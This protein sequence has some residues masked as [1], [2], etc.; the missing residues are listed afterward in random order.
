MSVAVTVYN[1]GRGLV[2]EERNIDLAAGAN[3]VRFMDVAE[4]IQAPT[5]RVAPIEGAPF[6]VLEQNYEYDLLSPA[7]LLD[8]FVGQT[9][10]LVQQKM[11]NNSTVE[12]SVEAKLLSN[13]SGTV[14][15]IGGKIVVNPPY[16][17]MVFPNVPE[18]LIAKPTLVWQ[19]GAPTAGKRR[20]EASYI[21]AGMQWNATDLNADG[22]KDP[23]VVGALERLERLRAR[24]GELRL[25]LERDLVHR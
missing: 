20:I 2:R 4:Q 3:E 10:T 14:W 23:D 13:N 18:N 5:V 11:M 17:R 15:E 9:I 21:T 22:V 24:T 8:K 16:S 7:K 25:V 1:D 12:E 19:I 6:N